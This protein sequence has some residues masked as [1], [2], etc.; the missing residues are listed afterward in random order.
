[1]TYNQRY[2]AI[3]EHAINALIFWLNI[4]FRALRFMLSPL[5]RSLYRRKVLNTAL[6]TILRCLHSIKTSV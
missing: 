4:N 6:W 5:S 3:K 1:M 2:M